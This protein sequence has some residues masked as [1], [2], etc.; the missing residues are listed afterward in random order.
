MAL[1]QT[2]KEVQCGAVEFLGGE[3]F[4]GGGVG[5]GKCFGSYDFAGV[6]G[7]C[8]SIARD[9]GFG[10][11]VGGRIA[12]C[13]GEITNRLEKLHFKRESFACDYFRIRVLSSGYDT[14]PYFEYGF[15]ME[16][17]KGYYVID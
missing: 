15:E 6:Y 4:G 5:G 10:N 11:G 14:T 1:F 17:G 2:V 9:C 16:H 13:S 12:Q 7:D 3:E 8:F